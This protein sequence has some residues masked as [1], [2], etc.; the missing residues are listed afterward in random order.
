MWELGYFYYVAR[1][2]NKST[3]FV[4][5]PS[6]STNPNNKKEVMKVLGIIDISY[7]W[8]PE[9]ICVIKFTSPL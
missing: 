3:Y 6:P 1:F 4:K 7:T 5:V 9:F 8:R 2:E